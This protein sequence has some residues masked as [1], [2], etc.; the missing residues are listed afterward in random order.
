M[1]RL[2]LLALVLLPR[3]LAFLTGFVAGGLVVL[4]SPLVAGWLL[5][6]WNWFQ[7]MLPQI[8][9]DFAPQAALL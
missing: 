2:S 8:L 5:A 3:A 4:H 1:L 9:A 7:Q 6:L